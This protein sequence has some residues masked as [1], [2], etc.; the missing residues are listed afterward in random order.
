M[1]L[2]IPTITILALLF[3]F[4]LFAVAAMAQEAVVIVP[5][6][7][8]TWPELFAFWLP[9]II[10]GA[11]AVIGSVLLLA[12][13]QTIALL[14]VFI[15][16]W[17][18]AKRQRDFTSAIM[19]KVSELIREGRWP[20][21]ADVRAVG[22]EV[23]QALKPD[24]LKEIGEYI[25]KYSPAAGRWAEVD[26]WSDRAKELL[27]TRSARAAVEIEAKLPAEEPWIAPHIPTR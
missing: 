7:I 23:T 25:N 24:L 1:T 27:A 16:E 8:D 6:E 4:L 17:I 22:G 12:M 15:R 11:L 9:K 5:D 2:R 10:N 13:R 14:P 19:S 26:V 3:F 21:A 18:D 20:T